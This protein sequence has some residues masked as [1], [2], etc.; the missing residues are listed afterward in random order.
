VILIFNYHS[1]ETENPKKSRCLFIQFNM[2]RYRVKYHYGSTNGET[3][4]ELRGGSEG[5]ALNE[6][7]RRYPSD[8]Y[9]VS[10]TRA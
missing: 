9:V 5:E 3:V 8:V 1:G 4:L 7:R 10:I 2:E 6:L